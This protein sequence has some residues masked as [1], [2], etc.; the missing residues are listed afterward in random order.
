MKPFSRF[1]LA[2]IALAAAAGCSTAPSM[3][4][5]KAGLVSVSGNITLDGKPLENAVVMFEAEDGQLSYG[6]TDSNGD[7]TLQFDSDMD[8]VTP[9]KKTVRI[10]TTAKII[11]LNTD[12]DGGEG[13]GGGEGESATAPPSSEAERVPE[14]YNKNSKVTVDVKPDESQTFDFE[15]SST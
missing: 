11:G 9:G 2:G 4:Y 8:G 1:L 15:L 13:E 12:D 14:K 7:Y 3:D 6:L 10:S 5:S